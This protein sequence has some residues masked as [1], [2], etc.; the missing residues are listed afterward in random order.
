[1]F[2]TNEEL[3]R[4]TRAIQPS[5]MIKWLQAEGFNFKVGLDGYPVVLKDHVRR[6]LGAEAT[7]ARK[8]PRVDLSWQRL[9]PEAV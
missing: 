1:M 8:K 5:R 6:L 3:Q 2:L 7:A 9:A 4:L